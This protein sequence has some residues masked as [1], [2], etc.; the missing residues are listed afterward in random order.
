[1]EAELGPARRGVAEVLVHTLH[2]EKLSEAKGAQRILGTP[3][4]V[5]YDA[6]L[7]TTV[8]MVAEDRGSNVTAFI[9][10]KPVFGGVGLLGNEGKGRGG[11]ADNAGDAPDMKVAGV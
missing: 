5:R 6:V 7:S 8:G 1:M 2:G 4:V 9:A 3:N 10:E 11:D